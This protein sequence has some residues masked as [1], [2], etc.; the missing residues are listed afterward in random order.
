MQKYILSVIVQNNSGVL[1]RVSSLI[2][3]RGYNIDSLTVSAT[4]NPEISRMSI[5]VTGDAAILEQVLKQVGKLEEVLIVEHLKETD[6]YCRE[7]VFVKLSAKNIDTRD[8]IR[9]IAEVYSANI[10]ESNED[11]MIAELTEIP[12]RIDAFLDVISN[13][14]IIEMCRSGVTAILK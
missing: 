3:R 1:A 12:S 9:Q 5:V 10:I 7:L 8:A 6:S 2:G 11:I 13:F 4:T 14:E